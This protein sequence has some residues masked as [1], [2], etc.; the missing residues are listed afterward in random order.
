MVLDLL[1]SLQKTAHV[2]A[3]IPKEV[4][5]QKA[6]LFDGSKVS[7]EWCNFVILGMVNLKLLGCLAIVALRSGLRWLGRLYS[8]GLQHIFYFLFLIGASEK[9]LYGE[10]VIGW[11]LGDVGAIHAFWGV[12]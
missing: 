10:A 12:E 11:G 3:S 8:R 6:K 7:L 9:F 1:H 4:D 2:V 5:K